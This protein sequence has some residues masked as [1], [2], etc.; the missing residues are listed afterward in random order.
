M[1]DQEQC[2]YCD[3]FGIRCLAQAKWRIIFSKE[4]PFDFMNVCEEHLKEYG[5]YTSKLELTKG[6]KEC[7][8]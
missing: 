3:E 6:T 2:S 5:Y 1:T 8:E 4:H 7:Q